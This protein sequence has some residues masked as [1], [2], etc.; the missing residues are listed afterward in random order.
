[1]PIGLA[2]AALAPRFLHESESHP[3]Q[4]DIPG[5]LT[6]T[7][8]LLGIVYGLTRAGQARTAGTTRGRSPA[9]SPACVLLVAF[10]FIESRA[11]HPLLP[12]RIFQNRTRAASFAA[13]MLAPAAMFAMFFFLSLF[14]QQIVGYS[15]L[16]AGFAFLPFSLGIVFGAGL[17][18]NLVSRID[19]RFLAGIG[20][21]MAAVALFGFSRLSVDDSPSAVLQAVLAAA[22]QARTSATGPRSCRSSS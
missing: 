22:R 1:M 13:M 8:G 5:A 15:P 2:A 9:W 19:P 20:T 7:L 6:G 14:I 10:A 12:L 16:E 18:S 11:E 17:A 3:G 21:L 4:L